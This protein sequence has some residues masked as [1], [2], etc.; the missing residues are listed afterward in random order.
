M[1]RNP[2][3]HKIWLWHEM[4]EG[5]RKRLRSVSLPMLSVRDCIVVYSTVIVYS[6]ALF[7]QTVRHT[8]ENH[9]FIVLRA[10]NLW[11]RF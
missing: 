5:H 9:V 6:T 11:Q 1:S 8:A 2:F 3:N 7:Y 4:D 10:L